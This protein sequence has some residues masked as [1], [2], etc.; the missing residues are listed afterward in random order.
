M[1]FDFGLIFLYFF[2]F[3][4]VLLNAHNQLKLS[5]TRL[6]FVKYLHKAKSVKQ[7]LND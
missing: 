2:T 5:V 6:A 3:T 1:M 7:S 4:E